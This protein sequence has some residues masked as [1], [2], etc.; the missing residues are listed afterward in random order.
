[1]PKLEPTKRTGTSSE[2]SEQERAWVL[3]AQKGSRE[4]FEKLAN[5]HYQGIF[6]MI[7]YRVNRPMDA[8]DLTQEVFMKAFKGLNRLT[9]EHRF[10]GWLYRI[11]VNQVRDFHRRKKFMGLI[12]PFTSE[13]ENTY[14]NAPTSDEPGPLEKLMQKRF[15][16]EAEIFLNRLSNMEKDVFL[17]RF[18][19]QLH[20]SEIA[21]ALNKGESTIKTHLY[22]ALSKFKKD[23][24]FQLFL[25]GE[26]D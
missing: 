13:E 12:K 25:K 17:L 5:Q 20:I 18:F 24:A 3:A 9:D 15:R 10:K 23:Y 8:E 2:A 7:Y 14:S 22:R 4:A 16:Q 6:Q 11:A 19:D 26:T 1:M 21:T